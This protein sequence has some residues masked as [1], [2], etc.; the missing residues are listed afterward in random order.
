MIAADAV[1]V[2][3]ESLVDV[4][5]IEHVPAVAGA[6]NSPAVVMLP[7]EA[8]QVTDTLAVNCALPMACIATL[9][10]VMVTWPVLW[11]IVI[12]VDAVCPLPPVAVALT[13][14]LPV[15]AGAV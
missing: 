7:H 13:V 10:G 2:S 1:P 14:Q 6:V 8:D 15:V 5:L 9:L 4:A 12:F 3:L 11:V